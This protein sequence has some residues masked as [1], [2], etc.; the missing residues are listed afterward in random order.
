MI[1]FSF[2]E[3]INSVVISAGY[4]IIIGA[5][6]TVLSVLFLFFHLFVSLP[7][8]AYSC[9]K[10]K[11]NPLKLIGCQRPIASRPSRG[12]IFDFTVVLIYGIGSCLLFYIACDG[13]IRL[14]PV[15][16]SIFFAVVFY[17]I[18]GVLT[19]RITSFVFSYFIGCLSVILSAAI[20]LVIKLVNSFKRMRKKTKKRKSP[21]FSAFCSI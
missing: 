10:K 20:Y 7:K 3:I 11:E 9:A 16:V 18:F 14:Y 5:F 2:A 4:G 15:I 21:K 6:Y 17:R 12:F 1:Y 13:M 8:I 19:E